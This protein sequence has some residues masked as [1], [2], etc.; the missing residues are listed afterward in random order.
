MMACNSS[1][2]KEIVDT[3]PYPPND[4][5]E[6]DIA[7]ETEGD[8]WARDNFDLQRTGEILETVKN[9]EELE[10]YINK[11]D[12]I[13]N[14]D[15]N[16]DGYVDYVSVEEY[17]DPDSGARGFSLFDR[18]GVNDIQEIATIIFDR[19]QPD[20]RGAR[21]YLDGNDQIYGD[22]YYYERNWLDKVLDIANYV[23]GDRREDNYYRSPYYYDNYPDNYTVYHVVET[24]V[25]RTRVTRL[26]PE[27]IF[28]RTKVNPKIKK[29]KL[30]S[31]YYGRSY[32]KVYAKFAKPSKQQKEFFKNNYKSRKFDKVKYDDFSK[33]DEKQ[34]K[35]SK[36][37]DKY[38]KRSEDFDKS[39]KD[40]NGK[41][42]KE[43]KPNKIKENKDKP[44][45]TE[46]DKGKNDFKK[47][48]KSKNTGK[49]D[50]GGKDNG[51]SDKGGKGNDK[52]KKK[53]KN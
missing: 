16:G 48:E 7:Y 22:D 13:N 8:Y 33:K 18:F 2:P 37:F 24:P 32:N 44:N 53:D 15:L 47:A 27:P 17:E 39:D 28:V 5:S 49:S 30:K 42:D 26:Y 4:N 23:F 50:K 9:P 25:Y 14:L 40:K 35:R 34:D 11:D 6:T 21:V 41:S 38:E 36:D 20:Q 43:Y 10:Y 52:G 1:Q 31:P 29:I 46:R 12:G 19:D 3:E 51:K 45:K